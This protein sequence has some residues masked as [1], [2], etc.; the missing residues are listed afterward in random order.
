MRNYLLFLAALFIFSGSLRSQDLTQ[1]VDSVYLEMS[2]EERVGQLLM[3]RAHSD[4]G[5]RHIQAVERFISEY[6]VGG[7]CFFQGTPKRQAELTKE[8]QN[9][10]KTPLLVS[11]DA[12]WGTGMRFKSD[13]YSF[14]KQMTVGAIDGISSKVTEQ[15]GYWIGSQLR[16]IGVHMNFAPVVDVNNNPQNPVINYRSF[17]ENPERVS[18]HGIAYMKGM[19]ASQVAACAKHFPGHGDTDVDSHLGLPVITHSRERLDSIELYPFRQMIAAGVPAIMVAHLSIPALDD[20][21]NRPTTLSRPTIQGLLREEMGFEGLIIT[22]A[23][24]MKGVTRHF[25]PGEAEVL[26]IEAGNDMICLPSNIPVVFRALVLAV[27]QNRLSAAELEAHVKRIL[28]LKYRLGL[29]TEEQSIDPREIDEKNMTSRPEWEVVTE[30]IYQ[31]SISCIKNENN[32]IPVKKVG[33]GL[34][35][36]LSIGANGPTPFTRQLKK[37]NTVIDFSVDKYFQSSPTKNM[38]LQLEVMDLVFVGIHDLSN[39]SSNNYGITEETIYFLKRLSEKTQVVV[40]LFGSPYALPS[41]E[42]LDHILVA[43]E[44]HPTAQRIAA[45]MLFGAREIR[46]RLPVSAGIFEEGRSFYIPDMKRLSWATPESVGMSSK[47]L[48]KIDTLAEELIANKAAPSCQILVAKE[49]KV[50]YHKSFGYHT[51]E[52]KNRALLSDVYDLAS[53]TKVAATTLAIM[54]LYEEGRI[55][56]YAPLAKY[57]P[58]VIGTNKEELKIIDILSHRAGLKPWIPF[59]KQTLEQKVGGKSFP[60]TLY[61]HEE[62]SRSYSVPVADQIFMK[63]SYVDSIYRC[64]LESPVRNAGHYKYSDL[65]LI[66]LARLIHSVDGRSLDQMVEEEFYGP[67]GLKRTGFQPLASFISPASIVPTEYDDYFRMQ[68]LQGFVHDMGAAMLGGVSGHAGL[69][70]NTQEL[71]AIFQMFLNKGVYGGE[72]FLKAA[73]IERFTQRVPGASRRGVGFDMKQLDESKS[74]N[75]SEWASSA[76]FG[77]LGF[78]GIAAWADPESQL[79]YLFLSNR[80]YPSMNNSKLARGSYRKKIHSAIYEAMMEEEGA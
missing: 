76:T 73:T 53:V 16:E 9:L 21:P 26:A 59:Y 19:H 31:N 43:Y 18:R 78:T 41:I 14:P 47:R 56:L 65:G 66:L 50:I 52:K 58:E 48:Q 64:I 37:Y 12:E 74:E 75:M 11:M 13:G 77:H 79:L 23:M 63:T 55:D 42:F 35:G 45:Q 25:S 51:Y 40:V 24:E 70:S 54:K 33:P 22:D 17:G 15:M 67:M 57:L 80:T 34:M 8:Y 38:L 72:R 36:A 5:P 10:A 4:L 2:L 49:S 6:H 29:H 27:K 69:F 44:D 3:I 46:G 30:T 60:S 7:L 39:T 61:Y 68:V 1:W 32:K 28:S 20:R 62:K 71:A